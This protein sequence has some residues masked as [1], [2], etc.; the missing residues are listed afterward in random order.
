[1]KRILNAIRWGIVAFR[2]PKYALEKYEDWLLED[3]INRITAAEN[4]RRKVG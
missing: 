1:M 4:N 2:M 3:F